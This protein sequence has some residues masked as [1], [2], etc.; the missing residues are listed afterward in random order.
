MTVLDYIPQVTPD[1]IREAAYGTTI[2]AGGAIDAQLSKMIAK[3]GREI[4]DQVPD[5]DARV[6]SGK[7]S[8]STIRD[9]IEA[10]VVRVTKNPNSYRQ[11]G[12]DDFQ[13]TLDNTVSAGGLYLSE[14]ERLKLAGPRKARRFGSAR[15]AVPSW[16]LPNA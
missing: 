7:V 13:A 1:D 9:V 5:L 8:P 3:A 12:I 14:A 4:M 10:M 16:R 11:V 6:A 2:P 15:L